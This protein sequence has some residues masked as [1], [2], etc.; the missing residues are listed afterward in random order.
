M[1][2][3]LYARVSTEEQTEGYSIDAQRRAF[4]TLCETK[5]WMP[6]REYVDEGKSARTEDI[7][8]RPAFKEAIEDALAH[9][10][11]ILVIHKIDRFSRR[12]L[13]TLEYFNKV[14]QAG[15][16]FISITEQM[17]FTTPWGKFT[18]SML[19]GLAELYSDNLSLETKKGWSER[20][21]QGLYCGTLPFG[22]IKG[23]DGIPIPDN[24]ERVI[25]INHQE[26]RLRNYDGLKTAFELAAQGKTDREIAIA[27]NTVGYKTTGTWGPR[28]FSK[29]TIKK[30][31]TN[32]F[33]L[34]CIPDG[35]GGW[36]KAKHGSFIEHEMFDEVQKLRER[37]ITSRG[38]IRLT[39]KTYSFTGIT[40]CA[41][42]D[43]TLR[44]YKSRG[45]VRLIC[46]GRLQGRECSQPSTFLDVYEEQLIAYL[47]TFRIPTDYQKKILEAQEKLQSA[48]GDGKQRKATL[49]A[50]LVR[51]K[52]QY[53]WGHKSRYEYL[54]EYN[55]IKR[56]LRRF[57]PIPD[58]M[59]NS[60]AS[61]LKDITQAWRQ[62]T[63]E[64]RNRLA[65]CLFEAIWIKDK[66]VYAVTPQPEFKPFFDLQYAGKAH[67]KAA[68][69]P[70]GDSNPRS[71]LCQNLYSRIQ[72]LRLRLYEDRLIIT[73]YR[74]VQRT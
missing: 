6:Y 2:A 15:L 63:Q 5:Q 11:D 12:L 54:G 71:L 48:Y 28:A 40:R 47:G 23:E 13:V 19:G 34:G 20:R 7:N 53:K 16:G 37:R 73:N 45:R 50:Q 24:K 29:D 64:Q 8:K 1:K 49:E 60:L 32:R 68:V 55:A 14:V 18:L 39:A 56:E 31:L 17:D 35:K 44:T 30:I 66:R 4:I 41:A 25:A 69:R 52:D 42:C 62:A 58:N 38:T 74:L 65:K 26:I 46:N 33:Y 70:R 3:A 36:L 61:F 59:L 51:L 9:Q 43:S 67:Y 10:Y 22:A 27:L 21:E 57:S 72:G